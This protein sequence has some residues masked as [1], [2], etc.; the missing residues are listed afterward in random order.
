ML[1]VKWGSMLVL[2]TCLVLLLRHG[3]LCMP[4]TRLLSFF[5]CPCSLL[6]VQATAVA[7][8]SHHT[9]ALLITAEVE[10]STAPTSRECKHAL[11][12]FGRG[13]CCQVERIKA[14]VLL[15]MSAFWGQGSLTGLLARL[16][17]VLTG[18]ALEPLLSCAW[19][20]SGGA[21]SIHLAY[22]PVPSLPLPTPAVHAGFHGQLGNTTFTDVVKPVAT[23]LGFKPCPDDDEREEETMP[24]VVACGSHHSASIS[25]RG[26]LFTWGLGS[27]G[28]LGLGHWTPL[29]LAVPRQCYLSQT[30][31]V[32][33]A[34]GAN[35]TLAI[36]ENGS[37]FS[38]GKNRQGQLGLNHLQDTHRLTKVTTLE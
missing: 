23:S 32:S 9:A 5:L 6:L 12:T 38:C 24:A 10:A 3:S 19:T 25:R 29:E 37:L 35:H 21:Q 7:C 36:A 33:I 8:G 22:P 20:V 30:R 16:A 17:Q 27:S 2:L 11:F 28:E 18:C 1:V 13:A 26:E 34:A 31:I 14:F 15:L 4:G